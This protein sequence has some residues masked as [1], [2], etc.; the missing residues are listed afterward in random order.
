MHI[1]HLKTILPPQDGPLKVTALSWSPTSL[2]LAA[3]TGDR[4]V[5]LFDEAG[6]RRDKFATKPADKVRFILGLLQEVGRMARRG[7]LSGSL[8]ACAARSFR[9]TDSCKNRRLSLK[10]PFA[11]DPA[12]QG[13]PFY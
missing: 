1:R 4:V 3:A 12:G 10:T 6:E 7:I 8:E 2:R 5:H 9:A 13:G 11:S